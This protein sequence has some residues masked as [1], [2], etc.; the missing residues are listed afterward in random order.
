MKM[1][2]SAWKNVTSSA[3]TSTK[4]TRARPIRPS[5]SVAA[6]TDASVRNTSHAPPSS[7]T[8]RMV[9]RSMPLRK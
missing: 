2:A 5:A 3:P 8:I 7:N 4:R 6:H 9:G 1:K